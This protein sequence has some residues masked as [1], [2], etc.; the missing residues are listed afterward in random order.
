MS[1][2]GAGTYNLPPGN[3]VVTETVISSTTHNS[4]MADIATALTQ[5]I[6]KDGQTT[7]TS[8]QSMGGFKHTQVADATARNQYA[9]AAQVQDGTLTT[10]GSVSGTDTLTGTV[11]PA[12]SAVPNAAGFTLIPVNNN[13]GAVTLNVNGLGARP[14]LKYSGVPLVAGDLLVGIPA[15]LNYNGANF[16]L[17]NPQLPQGDVARTSQPNN[18]TSNNTFSVMGTG[19]AP[20]VSLTSSLPILG[21]NNTA[22]TANNRSWLNFVNTSGQWVLRADLDDHSSAGNAIVASR[23]GSTVTSIELA[24]TTITLNSVNVTDYARLSTGANF[25]GSVAA[26]LLSGGYVVLQGGGSANTPGFLAFLTQDG[27]RRGYIGSTDGSSSILI[28]SEAGWNWKFTDTP[29]LGSVLMND[30]AL[31]Q[32]G[33]FANA[34]VSQSNVTQHQAALAIGSGQVTAG[35]LNQSSSFAVNSG[36]AGSISVCDSASTITIT[37]TANCLGADGK[38][39]LYIRRSTGAVTFSASGV[40]IRSPGAGTSITV[41]HGKAALIQISSTEFELAGNV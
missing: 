34:R 2:D 39:A 3:P 36:S 21:F 15:V 31:M 30:A 4:T 27:T 5:S 29:M 12:I 38:A 6:S 40:T 23:T 13:T 10:I 16:Y 37:V 19:V 24:A 9:T 26:G 7:Y 35:I 1:R 33:T 14:V 20:T 41:Q 32:S 17:E 22:A 18:F 28:D 11:S 25:L 8:N